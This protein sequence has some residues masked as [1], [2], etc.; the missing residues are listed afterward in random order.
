MRQDLYFDYRASTSK[1][2]TLSSY[3]IRVSI[4]GANRIA[5]GTTTLYCPFMSVMFQWE[6]LRRKHKIQSA[7]TKSHIHPYDILSVGTAL[8]ELL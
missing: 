7:V 4:A 3:S 2:V 6:L 8:A 1:Y 5:C